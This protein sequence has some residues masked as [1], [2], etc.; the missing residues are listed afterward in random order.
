MLVAE[1]LVPLLVCGELLDEL[2]ILA[3][4]ALIFWTAEVPFGQGENES[5]LQSC[6]DEVIQTYAGGQRGKFRVET[7]AR[8]RV[9]RS[10]T[11]RV[12]RVR[13]DKAGI[14]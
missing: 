8:S 11:C 5:V 4:S 13:R 14:H 2:V 9:G 6:Q 1:V 7:R 3:S 12:G 10:E